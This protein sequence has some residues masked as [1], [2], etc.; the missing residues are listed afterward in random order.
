MTFL[1][2]CDIQFSVKNF[3]RNFNRLTNDLRMCGVND[4]NDVDEIKFILHLI[5]KT[6][7]PIQFCTVN[8]ISNLF[9]KQCNRQVGKNS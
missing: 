4:A 9:Y 5:N 1:N 3:Y 8:V 2:D 6:K 7:N